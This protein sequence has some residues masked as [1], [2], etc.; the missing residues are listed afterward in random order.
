MMS[1]SGYILLMDERPHEKLVTW[2]EAYK[3]TLFV[4]SMTKEFPEEER[5]G[6]ISQMR[7]SA[8]SVPMNIAE[9]NAKRTA[10]DKRRFLD[11]AKGSLEELHCQCRL[12]R[13]LRYIGAHHFQDIDK[14]IHRLS[15]LLFKLRASVSTQSRAAQS[16]HSLPS[17]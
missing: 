10:K 17:L 3:L 7:R 11:I 13:D 16:L 15:F 5:Y 8:Y 2:Q 1:G 4:Y 9:G 6:L 12:S 14:R